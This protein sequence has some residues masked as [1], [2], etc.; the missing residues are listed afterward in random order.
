MRSTDPESLKN[1]AGI[2]ASLAHPSR[3][4]MVHALERGERT[5]S[6][7]TELVGS[8]MS[9]VSSHLGVLRN[10]GIRASSREGNRVLHRLLTPCL[11][12]FLDCVERV[13]YETCGECP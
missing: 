8:D 6:E 1:K 10:A 13:V 4:L 3:L 11:N 12:E 2:M 5:V 9:T 7:L